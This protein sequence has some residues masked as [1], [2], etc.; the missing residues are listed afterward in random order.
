MFNFQSLNLVTAMGLLKWIGILIVP[1]SIAIYFYCFICVPAP[2]KPD[3]VNGWWA[4]KD[5]NV[6]EPRSAL[7]EPCGTPLITPVQV[8]FSHLTPLSVFYLSAS[9]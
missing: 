3:L 4:V 2:V 9:F 1:F 7:I 5:E 6:A 8:D